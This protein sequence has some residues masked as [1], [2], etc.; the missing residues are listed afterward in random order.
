MSRSQLHLL[1][2]CTVG[3]LTEPAKFLESLFKYDKDNIPDAVI[4]KIQ[5]YMDNPVFTP[6]NIEKVSK[7]CTSLCQWVRSVH[8]KAIS[9]QHASSYHCCRYNGVGCL[10][11]RV[12]CNFTSTCI[13]HVENILWIQGYA[14]V[15]LCGQSR[16]S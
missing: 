6:A 15:S 8:C 14:Q 7:A 2:C 9:R 5:P 1:L 12:E 3:L 11:L 4:Q 13:I 10:R 16:G